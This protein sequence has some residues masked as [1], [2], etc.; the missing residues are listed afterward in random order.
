MNANYVKDNDYKF[1]RMNGNFF[2][3]IYLAFW[4]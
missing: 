2:E 1:V 3:N 4:K